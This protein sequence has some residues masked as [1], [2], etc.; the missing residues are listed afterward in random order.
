MSTA[1]LVNSAI[2]AMEMGDDPPF[3][4]I[5]DGMKVEMPPMSS[6]AIRIANRLAFQ[7]NTFA[8]KHE[9]GEAIVED[10]FNLRLS[11]DRNRRPVV[12]F[13][14][15]HRW[16]KDRPQPTEGDVWDVVPDLMVEVVSPNDKAEELLTKI[17]EYFE[18]GARQV[19]VIY[20]RERLAY[21]HESRFQVR[22]ITD[23]EELNGGNVLPGFQYPLAKLFPPAIPRAVPRA[24]NTETNGN[25]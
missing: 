15:C 14:S 13:M 17:R 1:T 8:A 24:L 23:Q 2:P 9:L 3:F 21:L 5:I 22:I 16:P 11:L 25:A 7:I 4:E 19:W 10:I 18:A 20:P 6:Y 12:A